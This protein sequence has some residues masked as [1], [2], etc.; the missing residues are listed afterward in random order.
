MSIQHSNLKPLIFR[1]EE[2]ERRKKF[3]IK[4]SLK[5]FEKI[6]SVI[7]PVYNEEKT[8]KKTL[9][10]IPNHL[11]YER[12]IVDD[13]STENSVKQIRKSNRKGIKII[14]HKKNEGYGAAIQTGLEHAS[15]EIIVTI[16]SDGQHNP[17]EIPKLLIPLIAQK[18][19]MVIGSR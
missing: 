5:S 9:D 8:I 16:D 17:K 18:A 6:V 4:S 3:T 11:K 15:G 13:G 12:L 2:T 10:R 1:E 14:Q 7:I 19:D